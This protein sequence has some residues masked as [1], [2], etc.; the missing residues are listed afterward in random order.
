MSQNRLDPWVLLSGWIACGCV[1]LVNWHTLRDIGKAEVSRQET[2]KIIQNAI[3]STSEMDS[4]AATLES[5]MAFIERSNLRLPDNFQLAN[6][7]ILMAEKIR[8]KADMI[9][10]DLKKVREGHESLFASNDIR[11]DSDKLLPRMESLRVSLDVLGSVVGQFE[12]SD[13][14]GVVPRVREASKIT[15][16]EASKLIELID[17]LGEEIQE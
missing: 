15:T 6:E 4:V 1:L 5:R 3:Q 7:A 16:E 8:F 17:N 11:F 10:G 9:R 12:D 14:K 2:A 13:W